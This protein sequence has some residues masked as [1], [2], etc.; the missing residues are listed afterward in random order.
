MVCRY[1]LWGENHAIKQGVQCSFFPVW[2]YF[3]LSSITTLKANSSLYWSRTHI[4]RYMSHM[5]L[6]KKNILN[7]TSFL[8]SYIPGSAYSWEWVFLWAWY[9]LL[10]W[11]FCLG[12]WILCT[13]IGDS[14]PHIDSDKKN[15]FVEHFWNSTS[16]SL[17]SFE[18]TRTSE[19]TMEEKVM[20]REL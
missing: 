13:K 3:W 6:F 12:E 8:V 5:M 2:Q 9:A 7:L 15:I 17:I 4:T 10:N 18:P 11:I 19:A 1:H 20:G 14:S 16:Q